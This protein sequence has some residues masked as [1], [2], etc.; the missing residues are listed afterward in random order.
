MTSKEHLINSQILQKK[1]FKLVFLQL[2]AIK[3]LFKLIII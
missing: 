2:Q 1:Y 3:I